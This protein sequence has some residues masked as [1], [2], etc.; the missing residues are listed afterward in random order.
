MRHMRAR[1][2]ASLLVVAVIT[3]G[4][5]YPL[6]A[7]PSP[8][9][10]IS[11]VP[12]RIA[13]QVLTLE[14]HSDIRAD[15]FNADNQPVPGMLVD[16]ATT[17]GTLATTTATT[18]S[19]GV[20]YT[21]VAG[22]ADATVTITAGP[23]ATTAAVT[24]SAAA[25]SVSLSIGPQSPT[26]GNTASLNALASQVIN[27]ATYQWAFGDGATETTTTSTTLHRY[28]QEGTLVATVTILDAA[29]RSG[30]ASVNLRVV[31]QPPAPPASTDPT[32]IAPALTITLTC[33][34]KPAPLLTPCNVSARW[35]GDMVPSQDIT[36]VD[37][38]WGDGTGQTTAGPTQ[39]HQNLRPGTFTVFV[40]V[41]AD[42]PT[43]PKTGTAS[44][45]VI[46]L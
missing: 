26:T 2:R 3:A 27:P 45:V 38:D 29:G 41:T 18:D 10:P 6:P 24:R 28:L 1:L 37:W 31:D 12:A 43:G 32:P 23:I 35:A 33:T 20:A 9:A 15:V 46:V 13:I 40:T 34:A 42:T 11:R 17:A 22:S 44:T 30:T 4:C 19:V 21:R 39:S 25:L 16:F 36:A 8:Q 14:R 5:A 7:A